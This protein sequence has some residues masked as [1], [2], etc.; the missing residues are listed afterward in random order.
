MGYFSELDFTQQKD[1][2]WGNPSRVQQLTD[3]LYCLNERLV[4]LE[5]Q[6]P[7]DVMDPRFDR[8]FYSECL[9]ESCDDADTMQG[10]LQAIRRTEELLCIAEE[11]ERLN[12]EE[13]QRQAAWR[14]TVRETGATPDYQIVLLGVFF[15][16]EDRSAAA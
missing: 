8:T 5:D 15:P 2:E 10:V 16:A 6:C 1:N 11:D 14:N 7:G 3:Q 9:T 4:D 13:R 12:N